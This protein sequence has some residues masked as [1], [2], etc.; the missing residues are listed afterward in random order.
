MLQTDYINLCYNSFVQYINGVISGTKTVRRNQ[1]S[2][3]PSDIKKGELLTDILIESVDDTA[4]DM[5]FGTTENE[6]T[7]WRGVRQLQV[8]MEHFSPTALYDLMQLRSD[9]KN[10]QESNL[11][12]DN[13][14]F[15]IDSDSFID[16][17]RLWGKRYVVSAEMVA[18]FY[19]GIEYTETN[20]IIETVNVSS[21]FIE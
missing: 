8:S 17:T 16:T 4:H 14:I 19:V 2:E 18:Q 21:N 6:K 9:I 12:D 3:M 20:G 5:S 11:L 15:Y 1:N 13:G 10:T 7:T